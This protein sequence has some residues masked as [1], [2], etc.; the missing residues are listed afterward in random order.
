MRLLPALRCPTPG[1]SHPH[2]CQRNDDEGCTRSTSVQPLSSF[3]K[4]VAHSLVWSGRR[5]ASEDE[6]SFTLD[7]S[8][9]H[10]AKS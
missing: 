9:I 10:D 4:H 6:G 3:R 1:G 5:M 2:W 8:L 7:C